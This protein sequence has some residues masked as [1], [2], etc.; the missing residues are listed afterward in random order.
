MLVNPYDIPLVVTITNGASNTD[1][2]IPAKGRTKISVGYRL[3][4]KDKTKFPRLVDT[5][6]GKAPK[7]VSVEPVQVAVVE[8]IAASP[9]PVKEIEPETESVSV[10]ETAV[11]DNS[12][13]TNTTET[14]RLS[15][16][17]N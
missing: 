9:E 8:T 1:I 7:P 4:R 11:V 16:R 17:K 3:S 10:E 6:E 15:K 13:S 14:I 12:T 2:L 5:E